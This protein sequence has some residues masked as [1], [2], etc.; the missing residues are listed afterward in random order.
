MISIYLVTTLIKSYSKSKELAV[1]E[2]KAKEN[3]IG[4]WLDKNPIPPS[5]WR[6][7]K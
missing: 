3:K 4:L 2:D 5:A 6:N 7:K 1:F